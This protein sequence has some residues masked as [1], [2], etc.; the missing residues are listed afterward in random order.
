MEYARM[1]QYEGLR[2]NKNVYNRLGALA[3]PALTVLRKRD[4]EQLVKQKIE[5][6]DDDV[7]HVSIMKMVN[8][9]IAEIKGAFDDVRNSRRISVDVVRHKI[10][11]IVIDMSEHP[12]LTQILSYLEQHDEYT[13]RHSIGVA[14]LSRLI[15]KARGLAT[16]DLLELTTAGFLHDIG[17]ARIDDAIINKPGKLTR[18]EFA[19]IQRHTL[20]GYEVLRNTPGISEQTALVALRHHER[21]DGSGYPYGLRGQQID[22]FS[23]IIAVADVFHAM[24]SKRVYKDPVP[25]YKVLQEMSHNAYGALEPETTLCFIRRIM[26]KMVGSSIVL[27]NGSEGKIVFISPNDPAYPVVEINGRYVDLSKEQSLYVKH[28]I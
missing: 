13:Y 7:E 27:S 20:Y 19:E 15:G 6:L 4:I 12:G 18:E 11:P 9:A 22:L 28:L 25:F 3:L 24:I 10:L 17:K 1:Y 21:E 8:G 14:L 5:L 2:L 26:D 23:K 16:I